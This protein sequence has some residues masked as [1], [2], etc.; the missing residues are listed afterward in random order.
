MTAKREVK[1][2]TIQKLYVIPC[3]D[4][5]TTWGF[6]NCF[7]ETYQLAQR[8][9]QPLPVEQDIGTMKVYD[10]HSELIGL[11]AKNKI[12]LGTWFNLKTDPMVKAVLEAARKER[13]KV[14]IFYGDT[15]PESTTGGRSWMEEHDVYGYISRST[16]FLKV[17]LLVSPGDDGGGAILTQCIVKI[18]SSAWVTLYEH[19]KF[20][21]PEMTLVDKLDDELVKRGYVVGVDVLGKRHANF[22][23]LKKAQDWMTFMRGGS[24]K[25]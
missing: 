9:D 12:D 15:N 5:W 20:Y 10:Y 7:D 19:P 11:V 8:L 16:G 1:V 25:P 4:G 22:K 2:D 21:V 13:M 6:Q 14:R 17:P 18:I 23:S 3:G 24:L